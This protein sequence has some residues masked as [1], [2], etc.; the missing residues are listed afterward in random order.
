MV[1]LPRVFNY[2][3]SAIDT[4]NW[5]YEL[6]ISGD[7]TNLSRRGIT[8]SGNSITFSLLD[9]DRANLSATYT[10]RQTGNDRPEAVNG[11][12]YIHIEEVEG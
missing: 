2:E 7:P 1:E 10:A 5:T 12:V 11:T 3:T 9:R 6:D 4:A 8:F